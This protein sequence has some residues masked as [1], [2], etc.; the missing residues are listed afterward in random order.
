MP[1]LNTVVYLTGPD[2]ATVRLGPG[3]D[4]P[5][6][7]VAEITNPD[8]WDGEPSATDEPEPEEPVVTEGDEPEPAKRAVRKR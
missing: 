6:W 3:D 2:G 7:A 1:R 4:V 8:C 5:D